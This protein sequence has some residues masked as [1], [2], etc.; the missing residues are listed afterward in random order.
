MNLVPELLQ[1]TLIEELQAAVIY[2]HL[3]NIKIYVTVNTLYEEDNQFEKLQDYLLFLQ[4]IK[5]DALI[6]QDI[7]LMSLLNNTFQIL[8]FICQSNKHL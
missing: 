7:G 1:Q 4:T 5:V 6:I 8:K 3:R 2:G